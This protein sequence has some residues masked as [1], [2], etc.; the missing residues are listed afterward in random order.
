VPY[1]LAVALLVIVGF[2]ISRIGSLLNRLEHEVAERTADLDEA[3][4]ELAK[5]ARIDPLT[6]VMNRRGFQAEAEVEIKRFFRHDRSFALVLADIDNFKSFNDCFGHACG[7]Q[8][9]NRIAD[10]LSSSVREVDR[11]ARWGGEEFILLL[12]ETESQGASVLA[13]K[14]REHIAQEQFEVEGGSLTMTMTFGISVHRKGETL[15]T[16]I[17]RAKIA[18][19]HGKQGGRNKV[20]IGNYKGLTL[21]Q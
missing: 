4:Q 3:N 2:L 9:L 6:G 16:T 19:D 20:M 1:V 8:V 14:L 21:V 18:L 11:V 10:T 17:A 12:P 13:E 15:E 7:D 5:A